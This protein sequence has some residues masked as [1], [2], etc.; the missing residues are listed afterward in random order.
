MSLR[1]AISSGTR[2]RSELLARFFKG[3]DDPT[4]ILILTLL[5]DGE[6]SVGEIVDLLG[7]PQGRVSSHLSC[8]RWCGYVQTRRQGRHVYY[9][10][11]DDRV[12]TLL[13]LAEDLVTEHAQA[14]ASCR[15]LDTETQARAART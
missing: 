1:T 4:R 15:V 2:L 13:Q 6:R 14:L 10:L 11:A 12:R 5:Q 3:L 8:L 7:S 9:R